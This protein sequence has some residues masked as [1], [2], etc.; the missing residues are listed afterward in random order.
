MAALINALLVPAFSLLPL[1]VL[2]RLN[3]GAAQF[4]WL[5][6]AVGAGLMV[7]GVV[8][9]AWGGFRNRIV[10]VLTGMVALGLAVIA[11]G[12]TPA[13]SFAWALFSL[14]CVGLIAPMVNGPVFAILQATIAPDYQGRVFSLVGSLAGAAAPLGL[15]VAA[16]VAEVVGVGAWYLAGGAV[17][18]AMGIAGFFASSLMR[19]EEDVPSGERELSVTRE[20]HSRER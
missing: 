17:C 10:T 16:P 5:S 8:L 1:L 12:L 2:Q 14:S 18:I 7:G 15:V 13:S 9:G 4:G 19:I 3:A 20:C 11:V 6:S